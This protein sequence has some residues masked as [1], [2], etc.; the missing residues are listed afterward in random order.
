MAAVQESRYWHYRTNNIS[1][2]HLNYLKTVECDWSFIGDVE[3]G[4]KA[5][6]EH[7]HAVFKFSRSIRKSGVAKK[8]CSKRENKHNEGGYWYLAAKYLDSSIAQFVKY[9]F[10]GKT[11]NIVHGD[12]N[13]YLDIAGLKIDKTMV[14]DVPTHQIIEKKSKDEILAENAEKKKKLDDERFYRASIG[15]I[16]W[17]RENDRK[18]MCTADFNRQLVWAQPDATESLKDKNL[19]NYFIYGASGTG[20]SSSINYLYNDEKLYKKIKTNEKWDSYFNLVH[21]TV[22]FD[23]LDSMEDIEQAVGG[24][25]GLKTMADAY[26]FAVRQNYGNRQLMIRPKRIIITSNYTPS[27][28]FST[29]NR[30]GR[31]ICHID[32]VLTTFKRR[33]KVMHISEWQKLNRIWFDQDI[34]RTRPIEEHP[35]YN[36]THE[37]WIEEAELDSTSEFI[38]IPKKRRSRNNSRISV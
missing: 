12:V 33:F 29:P 13:Q 4:E 2:E 31:Q 19:D 20:K 3:V 37:L 22:Y 25:E 27:A 21:E 34:L 14:G 5:K 23:E 30:Y 15:D 1:Q 24:Y 32:T 18:Y 17:F 16:T 26:P 7:R 38:S 10:K 11:E 35:D 6:G 28:V 9:V 8:V 36:S